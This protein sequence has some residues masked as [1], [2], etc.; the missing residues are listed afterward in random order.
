LQLQIQVQH[1]PNINIKTGTLQRI[2]ELVCE[3][4]I[5]YGDQMDM[6]I[7]RQGTWGMS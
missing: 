2:Y 7:R 5:R 1:N 3:S 4:N 6:E